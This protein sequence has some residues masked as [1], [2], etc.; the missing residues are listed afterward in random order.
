VFFS[1]ITSAFCHTCIATIFCVS[2]S[3][4]FHCAEGAFIIT[5]FDVEFVVTGDK[6]TVGTSGLITS[7]GIIAGGISAGVGFVGVCLPSTPST[8]PASVHV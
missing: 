7:I 5:L 6:V 2:D 4:R 3:Q 8:Y 1:R